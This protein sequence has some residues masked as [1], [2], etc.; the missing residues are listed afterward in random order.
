MAQQRASN[1]E[2]WREELRQGLEFRRQFGVE[3]MWAELEA[4]FYDVHDFSVHSGPNVVAS[5]GDSL[6]STLTVPEA[7]LNISGQHPSVLDTAKVVESA[8]N[9]IYTELNIQEQFEVASLR[10]Y[11]WGVGI[12]KLGYDS[13]W[14]W[15]QSRE[16]MD[17]GPSGASVTQ[18]D[19]QGNLLE[20]NANI[21][22]G[23]PWVLPVLPH[24]FVVPW[25]TFRIQD[26][27]WC[28]HRTIRHIED[29]RKDPKYK[30]AG[31]VG[32]LSQ[33]DFVNSY[34]S[35]LKPFRAGRE[36]SDHSGDTNLTGLGRGSRHGREFVELWEIHDRRTNQ[37][38]TLATGHKKWVREATGLLPGELP[39]VEFSFVPRA[40]AFWVTSDAK[41]LRQEQAELSDI[42]LQAA[43]QR[44]IS[45]LRFLVRKGAM[46]EGQLEG[47]LSSDVG[48]AA[49][50]EDQIANLKD[51]IVPLTPP[52]NNLMLYQDAEHVRANAR[53]VVGQS[54]NQEGVFAGARTSATEAG[55]VQ[56]S[57]SM[58]MDRRRLEV[59][60]AHERLFRKINRVIFTRWTGPKWT[61]V[62]G[63]D[64]ARAW[65]QFNGP[66]IRGEYSYKVKFSEEPR[67]NKAQM[68][69][70]AL[71]TFL[72]LLGTPGLNPQALASLVAR[73]FNNPE[74]TAVFAG[75]T[76]QGAEGQGV[77]SEVEGAAV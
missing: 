1:P 59:A 22:P 45:V 60:R 66:L 58:R 39:F 38:K 21:R 28:A 8:D 73:Q 42:F 33:Q 29:L 10:A 32:T 6:L 15:D 9:R 72:G 74:L 19:R 53:E 50:V 44:R 67:L 11:L 75:A 65:V 76:G 46:T 13:E 71:S 49:M 35:V 12:I 18:F 36:F 41:F 68:D 31:L 56:Q 70:E 3:D 4:M 63:P 57:S 2:D 54:R 40:R 17:L 7:Y 61:E 37:V 25:G 64:G 34:R 30:T 27:P 5:Q 24:D 51:A 16:F 26:A 43:K 77:G 20:Y 52:N 23:M 14:G 69:Q 62:V 48:V 47:I 55:I